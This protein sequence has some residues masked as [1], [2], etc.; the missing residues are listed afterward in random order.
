MR[1]SGFVIE[2]SSLLE[3]IDL[4]VQRFEADPEFARSGGF[5]AVVLFENDLD[6]LHL[7]VA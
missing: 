3:L 6:V 5:V 7:D 1:G 4:V 2:R